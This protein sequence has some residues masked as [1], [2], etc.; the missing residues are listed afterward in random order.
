VFQ[1]RGGDDIE[2]I[3]QMGDHLFGRQPVGERRESL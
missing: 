2:I 3:V 1:D